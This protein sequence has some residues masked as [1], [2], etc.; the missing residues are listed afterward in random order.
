M[1]TVRP[2]S[3]GAVVGATSLAILMVLGTMANAQIPASDGTI[4]GCYS[5]VTGHLRVID[6][7][8]A[9]SAVETPISWG[10]TGSQGPKG[11]PG[12]TWQG[13]WDSLTTYN[14]DDAVHWDGDAFVA[15]GTPTVGVDPAMDEYRSR[16][17]SSSR[18]SRTSR[19]CS[20]ASVLS[21]WTC[22]SDRPVSPCGS[23]SM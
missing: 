13:E 17:A 18:V 7:S 9:C 22:A 3:R 2:T 6:E 15:T 20:P 19:T 16:A 11:D 21:H 10:G 1:R 14:Q 8:E 23:C 4:W 5:A 12:L